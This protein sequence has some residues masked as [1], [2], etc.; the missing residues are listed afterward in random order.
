M[1]TK[2]VKKAIAEVAPSNKPVSVTPAIT[3]VKVAPVPAHLLQKSK[4]S[5]L[6][7]QSQHTFLC[8]PNTQIP[9]QK[10]DF[11][12]RTAVKYNLALA[13]SPVPRSAA[14]IDLNLT[15]KKSSL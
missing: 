4:S 8:Q 5:Q 3:G 1:S 13:K 6:F 2:K 11:G 7:L 14:V 12:E 10:R 9:F 15:K